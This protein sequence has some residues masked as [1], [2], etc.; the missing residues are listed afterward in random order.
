[1]EKISLVGLVKNVEVLRG[2]KKER[3]IARTIRR[4]KFNWIVHILCSNCFLKQIIEGE[5]EA[6]VSVSG[7]RGRTRKQLLYDL[8]ERR[9]YCKLKEEAV[10]RTLR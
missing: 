3:N 6:R 9:L 2:V 7:R 10:D 4:R 8:K 5:V 1:M